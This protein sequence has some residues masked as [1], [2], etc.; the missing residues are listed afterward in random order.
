MITVPS[1]R[2][3]DSISAWVERFAPLIRP[4]GDVLDLACGRGRHLR[5][6]AAQGFSVTGVDIDTTGLTDLR[7]ATRI[8]VIEHDLERNSWP[9]QAETF[10]A[11]ICI[12]YL[13]RPLFTAIRSALRDG[14]VLIYATFA[15]GQ[16]QYGKPT[17]PEFLLQPGEL[18][19]AY[20]TLEI[21]A[22]EH[23][24]RGASRPSVR[25]RLC[26]ISADPRPQRLD[27]Q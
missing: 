17:S 21:V 1:E 16:A 25:Q 26:A 22:Y 14:G 5:W 6:L 24:I 8:R 9:F 7:G 23:G 4:G 3:A 15:V 10:D 27:G 13:H 11:V 19:R 20:A 12:N 2:P 18:L